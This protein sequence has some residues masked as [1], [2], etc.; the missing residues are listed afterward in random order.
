MNR[1][2]LNPG[3]VPDLGK[4]GHRQKMIVWDRITRFDLEEKLSKS[5][6]SLAQAQAA[7]AGDFLVRFSSDPG[8]KGVCQDFPMHAVDAENFTVG[9]KAVFHYERHQIPGYGALVAITPE[10]QQ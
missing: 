7:L 4:Y 2:A 5:D 10:G 8:G 3:S 6:C 9:V 1:I